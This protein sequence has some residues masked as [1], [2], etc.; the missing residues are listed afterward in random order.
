MIIKLLFFFNLFVYA[1]IVSQSFM[2]LIALRN[3]QERLEAAAYIELRKLLDE[4]L[5]QNLNGLCMQGC[6]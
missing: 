3:V 6:C 2:Y 4:N 1:V 5:L